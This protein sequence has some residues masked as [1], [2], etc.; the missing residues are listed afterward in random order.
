[1]Y[2]YVVFKTVITDVSF[3]QELLHLYGQ[4]IRADTVKSV[5]QGL[6]EDTR[7]FICRSLLLDPVTTNAVIQHLLCVW[8]P[9]FLQVDSELQN[10]YTEALEL[11]LLELEKRNSRMNIKTCNFF[12]FFT[13]L[14]LKIVINSLPK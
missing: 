12:L 9:H 10:I 11:C 2:S 8:C 5:V 4:V 6:S 3:F 13:V 14:L 7:N 1:V